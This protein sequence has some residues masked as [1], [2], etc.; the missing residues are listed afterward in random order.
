MK[1]AI[2]GATGEVGWMMIK[3]LEEFEIPVSPVG[4][5]G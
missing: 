2:V 1:I 4:D 3:C 5:V